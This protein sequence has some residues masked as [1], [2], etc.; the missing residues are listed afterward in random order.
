MVDRSEAADLLLLLRWRIGEA[1][2]EGWVAD[3]TP[4]P[5]EM[6]APWV[7]AFCPFWS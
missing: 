2:G 5:E 3:T 4:V 7:V 6:V 1:A